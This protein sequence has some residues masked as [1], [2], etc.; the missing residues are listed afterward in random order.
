MP[1]ILLGVTGGGRWIEAHI[2]FWRQIHGMIY[3]YM[4][5]SE[6]GVY[7]LSQWLMI[8]IPII[9]ILSLLFPMK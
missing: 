7:S 9:P 2:D 5:L 1:P 4:G 6:N 8:I 3:E